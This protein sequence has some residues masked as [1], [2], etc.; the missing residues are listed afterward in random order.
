MNFYITVKY[1]VYQTIVVVFSITVWVCSRITCTWFCKAIGLIWGECL[2]SVYEKFTD[3]LFYWD[4]MLFDALLPSTTS[5]LNIID[6]LWAGG[7]DYLLIWIGDS[8]LIGEVST[9]TWGPWR[10]IIGV[11][12]FLSKYV[13]TWG[14]VCMTWCW[15]CWFCW[16]ILTFRAY[17]LLLN[18]GMLGLWGFMEY[19][20][21]VGDVGRTLFGIWT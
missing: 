11:V 21:L 5:F 17:W 14:P 8:L 2:L 6:Y 7:E 16:T 4:P 3:G 1:L 10:T 19:D 12:G 15:T 9:T 13:W 20:W 18:A